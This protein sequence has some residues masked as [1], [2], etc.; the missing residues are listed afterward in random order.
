MGLISAIKNHYRRRKE[1]N[2][3]GLKAQLKS[4]YELGKISNT[5]YPMAISNLVKQ[6][7]ELEKEL[8]YDNQNS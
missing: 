5:Y 6:I 7:A 3:A 2:L 4:E 8:S 1:I